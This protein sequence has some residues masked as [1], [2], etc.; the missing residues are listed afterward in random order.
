MIDLAWTC[1]VCESSVP[2]TNKCLKTAIVKILIYVIFTEKCAGNRSKG[3]GYFYYIYKQ[4][5]SVYVYTLLMHFLML[6]A[7]CHTSK[8]WKIVGNALPGNQ[9]NTTITKKKCLAV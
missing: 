7:L 1:T 8:E 2:F 6:L 9:E 4:L 5:I 3:S